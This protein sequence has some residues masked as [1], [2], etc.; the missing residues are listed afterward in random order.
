MAAHL[1]IPTATCE[2]SRSSSDAIWGQGVH[3]SAGLFL[4]FGDERQFPAQMSA[5]ALSVHP[6]SAVAEGA[7][8]CSAGQ[9][10]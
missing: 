5:P 10:R 4:P 3:V 9:N 7:D 6:L 8:S 2:G 1:S